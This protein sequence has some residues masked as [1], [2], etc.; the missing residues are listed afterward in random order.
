MDE[1]TELRPKD[2]PPLLKEINDPPEKLYMRGVMPSFEHKWLCV[3]GSRKY[4]NYGQEVC[5]KLIRGLSGYRI[6]VVSGLAMGIDSL[7]H[8]FA[9]EAGLS[10][11]AVPGSGIS[12]E[13]IYP[14]TNFSLAKKI[15][16]SGGAL[17]SEYE[18]DFNAT[19]WSFPK[20]NRIM[21]GLCHGT[22][23]IEAGEKSGTLI[24]A[25]LAM[26]YNREVMTVP[27]SVFSEN[28]RGP[29]MLI[30]NGA[31]PVTGSADILEALGIDV[32][33]EDKIFDDEH[34]S[35]SEKKVLNALSEPMTKDE[36]FRKIEMKI[37]EANVLLS[38]MEIK[39]L[40]TESL[41]EVKRRQ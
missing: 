31:T 27:G 29:H 19:V 23:V 25:R 41:G 22:L 36:L 37:S 21:A 9:L 32:E 12:D 2:F 1:I 34:L 8:R 14:K 4:S 3:V 35:E 33:A 10:T 5:E 11:I 38:T 20:R 16:S 39:G 30:R 15:L 26:E 13:A 18:P 24:T 28:S 40:I 17:I 7:A 6:T